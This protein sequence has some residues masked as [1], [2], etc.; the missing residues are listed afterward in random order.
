MRPALI[1]AVV[2]GV[3]LAGCGGFTGSETQSPTVDDRTE[4]PTASES[5]SPTP[6]AEP[7]D[8][9]PPGVSEEGVENASVLTTAHTQTLAQT[10]FVVASQGKATVVRRG[11]L[12][13]AETGMKATV[14]ANRTAYR[15]TRST[16]AS[17]FSR[18]RDAWFN[19]EESRSQ[20]FFRRIENPG[21]TAHGKRDP[22]PI[23]TLAGKGVLRSHF[24]GG[25]FTVANVE[26]ANETTRVTL[27]ANSV[28][29]ETALLKTLPDGAER[30]TSYE[31][32]AVVDEQ[33]R[34]HSFTATVEYVIQGERKTYEIAYEIRQIGDVSVQRPDWV[35][36]AS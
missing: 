15:A 25:N 19:V 24:Q 30:V 10:G 23:G 13:E 34:I 28:E 5:P 22:H 27:T 6:T 18:Q 36:K 16:E 4:S 20:A 26:S 3:L 21:E 8:K 32:E 1:A 9:L 35:D 31:G 33:G 7:Q 12:V 14:E 29:N 17:Y 11:T 2:A